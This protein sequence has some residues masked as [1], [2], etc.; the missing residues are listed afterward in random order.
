MTYDVYKGFQVS[1]QICTLIDK[2]EQKDPRSLAKLL[3]FIEKSGVEALKNPRLLQPAKQSF[4]LGVTGPPGAGKSTFINQLLYILRKRGLSV[5]VLA[6]DPSSPLTGG[7]ILGDRIRYIDHF[8]DENVFIRSLGT[9]GS[10]GGLCA[11]S[12][13]MLRAYDLYHF[14]IVLVE[15]VGVGQSELDI[16]NVADHVSILL[17]PESGD[18]IQMMKAGLLEVGDSFVVN[19]ADRPGAEILMNELNAELSQ[20][21]HKEKPFVYK[22]VATKGQGVENY[23]EEAI[24]S[25]LK[26]IK[27]DSPER[28]QKEARA[29]LQSSFD[30]FWDTQ[31]KSIKNMSQFKSIINDFSKKLRNA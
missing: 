27:R 20:S 22:T 13:L 3:T 18:S 17:V 15:T 9:R 10:L 4:R 11:S 30:H 16:V 5:G 19:K 26:K 23:L 2:V 31:V 7:A 24:Y 12:Y 29:L 1:D 6:V 14:D 25:S 21:R 28:L 8:L